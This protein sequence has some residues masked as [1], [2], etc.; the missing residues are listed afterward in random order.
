MN[1]P[2]ISTLILRYAAA[3]IVLAMAPLA[4]GSV[5]FSGPENITFTPNS[6]GT[7]AIFELVL[8]GVVTV[9]VTASV[10]PG[11]PPVTGITVTAVT[12]GTEWVESGGNPLA[13]PGG[14]L[15]D[16]SDTFT[17]SPGTLVQISPSLGDFPANG[18]NAYLGIEFPVGPDI[19]FGYLDLATTVTNGPSASFLVKDWAYESDPGVGILTGAGETTT[20]TPEPA[21]FVLVALGLVGLAA[22]KHR[23]RAPAA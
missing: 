20:A 22:F 2:H 1:K 8:D 18:G 19:H 16:G 6:P 3:A 4:H 21:S 23:R 10:P 14:T 7:F 12:A 17:A 11:P 15:V 5:I 9:G 13:L